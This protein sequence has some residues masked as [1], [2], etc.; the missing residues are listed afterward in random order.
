M[1]F[2]LLVSISTILCL[3]K[4]EFFRFLTTISIIETKKIKQ[5]KPETTYKMIKP[6]LNEE[7]KKTKYINLFTH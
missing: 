7:I 1:N 3:L 6:M 2:I 4:T 5:T